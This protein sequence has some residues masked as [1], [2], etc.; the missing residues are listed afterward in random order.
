MRLRARNEQIDVILHA[1]RRF[2]S[3]IRTMRQPFESEIF[4]AGPAQP[5]VDRAIQILELAQP[6]DVTRCR[7]VHPLAR[8]FRHRLARQHP[9]RQRKL[10]TIRKIERLTP[11]GIAEVSQR[12]NSRIAKMKRGEYRRRPTRDAR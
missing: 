6:F 5:L 1:R 11:F 2:R 7:A 10:R 4:H 12:S 9:Q 8:P 3:K